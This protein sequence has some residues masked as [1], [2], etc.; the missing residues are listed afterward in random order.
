MDPLQAPQSTTEAELDLILNA[1]AGQPH[2]VLGM[3]PW[4]KGE[5]Q[6]LVVRCFLPQALTCE[7]VDVEH[8]PEKRYPME[9]VHRAGFFE[10]FIDA[11]EQPEVFDY[12]LR[13]TLPN[14]E[15]RQFYDPFRFLPTL[16]DQ[17]IYLF[18]QGNEH[19]IYEKLGAHVRTV[20]G[21]PGVAFAV[22]APNA[23]RVSVVGEFNQWDGRLHPMRSLGGSGVWELFIPGL[24]PGMKYKYE[25]KGP[26]GFLRLKSDP[27]AIQF[28]P[29]PHNASIVYDCS[30]FDWNDEAWMERR[31]GT[32]WREEP[33]SIYE[34]HPASWKRVLEDGDRP[35]TYREMA[36]ELVQYVREMGYTHVEF[37][38]LAEHPFAGSWGYQVT[39]FFAP[40]HRFGSPHDFMY[41]VDQLHQAGIGVIVDWVPGHFPKDAFALAEFDGTHLYE[42]A[43]PRQG[44]HLEWGT[45]VFNYGRHEVKSFLVASA[46]SWLDR[47]HVDGFRVDAVA[48]M[49]YLDYGREEGGWIPNKYGG[50][51]NLE[52]IAFLREV[53]GLIHDYY[54]GVVTIAEESTSFGGVTQP[55][56][57]GGLGFDFKWNMGWMHDTLSY[58]QKDPIHRKFHHNQLTFGALYNFSEAFTL[59]YSHDEV[60]HGKSSMVMKMGSWNMR[61]KSRNL[62]ALYA[63]MWLWP[64]KKTLFMGSDFGQSR[65]WAYDQSLD[66][67]LLQYA[68]HGGVQ[69]VVRDLNR[70]YGA[71]PSLGKCDHRHDAFA[72]LNPDD[73]E[74]STISFVRRGDLPG[75]TF[76][77]VANFTPMHREGYR[78]GLPHGGRW[79][80]VVNTDA[81]DYGGDNQGNAGAVETEPTPCDGQPQSAL[82]TLPG[83]TSLVF[84]FEG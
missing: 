23:K 72:W 66:W 74:G 68:D 28:E 15:V 60:V 5:K 67:H 30:G 84:R 22:W 83:L 52:A 78:I 35:L 2:A 51:E 70:L 77:L 48:S 50:N 12:R 53:N 42:H 59:V 69:R 36:V 47:F 16:S 61:D 62:R 26:D 80:E 11:K 33:M 13:V 14:G 20:D 32:N 43:D 75:D 79:A 71:H 3:H 58:F 9:Q 54:P 31:K 82:I 81:G 17:D 38:P 29:P 44:Q 56:A 18:N 76:V 55:P 25:L 46:L 27:Y 40:T 24:E 41:L 1:E 73:A 7:V 39:G 57:N 4:K 63:F 37:M 19:R 64:G 8:C 34:V 10:G 45:L 21:V 49:L 6:G 65:E